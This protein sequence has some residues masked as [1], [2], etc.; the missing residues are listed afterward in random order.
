MRKKWTVGV[1]VLCT[2]A[3]S[4]AAV[5]DSA[6]ATRSALGYALSRGN[7][8]TEN[9]NFKFDIAHLA[10][11]WQ[12]NFGLDGLYGASNGINTAQRGDAHFQ[13]DLKLSEHTFWFGAL[14]YEDD[15]FSGFQYQASF[16]TGVGHIFMKTDTN[17]LSAQIG[18][19]VRQLRP[20][21]LVRNDLG[22]VIERI[23]GDRANDGVV[24]GALAYEHQFNPSTKVIEGF[25]V[26]Y[27]HANT[28][29]KNSLALQVKMSTSLALAVGWQVNRNSNPPAGVLSQTDTLTT[30]NLVYEI[31]DPKIT[32]SAVALTQLMATAD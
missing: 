8:H 26:E 13:T 32:P 28:S 25:Q 7:S 23:P 18:A 31:K 2:A 9:G 30:V 24:N 1:A 3:S 4:T 21:E 16:S 17:K 5:A 6:W 29:M 19:G 14:R 27:G 15:R 22:A 10:G 12:Y 20:E 11:Q